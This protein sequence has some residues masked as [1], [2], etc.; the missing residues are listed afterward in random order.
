[1]C[2]TVSRRG[3]CFWDSQPRATNCEKDGK[4]YNERVPGSEQGLD[5]GFLF[6][7]FIS[8][9]L[10][11]NIKVLNT[12]MSMRIWSFLETAILCF[13]SCCSLIFIDLIAEFTR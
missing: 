8:H 10:T 2:I 1:M 4:M 13:A 11:K 9:S 5:P 12:S 7:G 3:M 6:H